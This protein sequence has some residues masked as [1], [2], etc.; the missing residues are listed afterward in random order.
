M[1]CIADAGGS[2]KAKVF[3][4]ANA[5][6]TP[7]VALSKLVPV[8]SLHEDSQTYCTPSLSPVSITQHD[9]LR[10]DLPLEDLLSIASDLFVQYALN[11]H[12][13]YIPRDFIP[14]AMESML[15]LRDTKRG[16]V[17]YNLCKAIGS[18][19]E[20]DDDSWLPAK[21]MPMGLL[22]FIGEFYTSGQN[23]KVCS[24]ILKYEVVI[25]NMCR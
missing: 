12:G 14:L 24:P 11:K 2:C 25:Y 9:R 17:I 7:L 8:P 18:K 16:N 22:Q 4:L 3:R 1:I 10:Q 20:V 23:E 13:L 15:H 21:R 5:F 6:E 19:R